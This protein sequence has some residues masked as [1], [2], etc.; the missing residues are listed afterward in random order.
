MTINHAYE[1]T[2]CDSPTPLLDD[3]SCPPAPL[4]AELFAT[5]ADEAQPMAARLHA[6]EVAAELLRSLLERSCSAIF[7]DFYWVASKR[8]EPFV[9]GGEAKLYFPQARRISPDADLTPARD[10]ALRKL[11]FTH[12]GGQRLGL[13]GSDEP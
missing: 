9:L 4:F 12:C 5:A 2:G 6:A 7:P 8:D 13:I 11:G 10:A 3:H 1:I